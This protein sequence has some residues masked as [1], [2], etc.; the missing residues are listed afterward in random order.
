MS[1]SAYVLVASAHPGSR[2][3]VSFEDFRMEELVPFV[4]TGL[5][6]TLRHAVAFCVVF[7]LFSYEVCEWFF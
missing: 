1:S 6:V 5:K 2:V 7:T 3:C 4:S